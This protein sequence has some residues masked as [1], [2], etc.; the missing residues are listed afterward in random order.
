MDA[1]IGEH[2]LDTALKEHRFRHE[3]SCHIDRV[4]GDTESGNDLRERGHRA[5]CERGD[6]KTQFLTAIGHEHASTAGL[7]H[8]AEPWAIGQWAVAK[9]LHY[10]EHVF[11]VARSNDTELMRDASEYAVFSR[12]RAGV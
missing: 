4:L 12:E 5:L 7:R 2:D 8:D 3:L 11:F 1:G 10:V 6:R 9:C